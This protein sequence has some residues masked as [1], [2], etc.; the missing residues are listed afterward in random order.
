MLVS[1]CTSRKLSMAGRG[2]SKMRK[3]KMYRLMQ[4]SMNCPCEIKQR[5]EDDRGVEPGCMAD[6]YACFFI[7]F[8]SS[9]YLKL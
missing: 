7:S 1:G 6:S 4:A 3:R 5:R 8:Q 9:V 2:C